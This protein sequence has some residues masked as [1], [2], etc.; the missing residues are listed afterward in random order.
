MLDLITLEKMNALTIYQAFEDAFSGYFVTFE[1]NPQ[2]HLDR[3][4]SAGVDFSLSYGVKKDGKLVAFIL[5]A[6]RGDMVMNL[7]TGVRQEFQG[8]GLTA[9]MYEKILQEL[10]AKG[11]RR[12]VLEVIT[13]NVKAIRAYEKVGFV[14]RRRL[15]CWKGKVNE[16]PGTKLRHDIRKVAFSEEHEKLC[17]YPHAFEQTNIVILKRAEMLELH[18]LR[19]GL[20][21]VAYAIWNPWRMNLVRLEGRDKDTLRAL[22]K[23]MKLPGQE[24]G[25]I[26]VDERNKTVNDVLSE[27]GLVNYLSQYEMEM[28]F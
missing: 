25:I 21:L 11:F 2:I 9:L 10:P 1:K 6:P 19:E 4:I 3:W 23:E 7:A 13:E 12:S 26:N 22:L 24:I 15:L 28:F 18:E 16:L 27:S 14:K 17:L 20:E 5:H 8:Q